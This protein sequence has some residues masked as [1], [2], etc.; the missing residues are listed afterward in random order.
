MTHR[1]ADP[2]AYRRAG[3][4]SCSDFL[5]VPILDEGDPASYRLIRQAD[6][7][8][9]ALRHDARRVEGDMTRA[10]ERY[11]RTRPATRHVS[12]PGLPPQPRWEPKRTGVRAALARLLDVLM[13]RTG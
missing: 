5:D 8:W 9:S 7:P 3:L 6:D 2:T 12:P 13:G 11:L 10:A 1:A 4:I